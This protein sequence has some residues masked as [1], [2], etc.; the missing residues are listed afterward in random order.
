MGSAS[1]EV[2]VNAKSGAT[3]W[4][5]MTRH[6]RQVLDV[7]PMSVNLRSRKGTE[8]GSPSAAISGGDGTGLMAKKDPS[9]RARMKVL[10]ERFT[11]FENEKCYFSVAQR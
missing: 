5:V 3:S 10:G 4:N 1:S 9:K 2:T 11:T 7:L 6:E 8:R